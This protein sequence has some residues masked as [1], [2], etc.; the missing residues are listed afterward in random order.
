M[1][2]QLSFLSDLDRASDTRKPNLCTSWKNAIMNEHGV[3]IDNR[4]DIDVYK[5]KSKCYPRITIHCALEYPLVYY[6]F[7][8]MGENC[9]G[10]CY[11]G[12]GSSNFDVHEHFANVA[13]MVEQNLRSHIS[14]DHKIPEKMIREAIDEFQKAITSTEAEK[15]YTTPCDLCGRNIPSHEIMDYEDKKLC[16]DCWENK[17]FEDEGKTDENDGW[18]VCPT[19]KEKVGQ[20]CK[21][22]LCAECDY[23]KKHPEAQKKLCEDC[24]HFRYHNLYDENDNTECCCKLHLEG[25]NRHEWTYLCKDFVKVDSVED[26]DRKYE[27][28]M[29]YA[30]YKGLEKCEDCGKKFRFTYNGVCLPCYDKKRKKA[31]EIARGFIAEGWKE[32]PDN[33]KENAMYELNGWID[34]RNMD[35]TEP[36]KGTRYFLIDIKHLTWKFLFKKV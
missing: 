16:M 9:G 10:G 35:A 4:I 30:S 32:V 19:C 28:L 21:S 7:D 2:E 20:L 14:K 3:F 15:K 8:L 33:E 31:E 5:S 29:K 36:R 18:S 11:P 26:F 23:K 12:Y 6:S 34:E 1:S 24:I 27:G 17:N 25:K 22:G 13:L